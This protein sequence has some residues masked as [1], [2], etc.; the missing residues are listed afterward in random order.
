MSLQRWFLVFHPV[1]EAVERGENRGKINTTLDFME[2]KQ[3]RAGLVDACSQW[4]PSRVA[5]GSF[6]F[7]RVRLILTPCMLNRD[8]MI[9]FSLIF[10]HSCMGLDYLVESDSS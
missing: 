6:L 2:V 9:H 4:S 8:V 5:A 7:I 3:V 10:L 1:C